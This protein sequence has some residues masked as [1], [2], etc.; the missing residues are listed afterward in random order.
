LLAGW[1]QRLGSAGVVALGV[2]FAC[3][4]FYW[5]TVRPLE[6]ALDSQRRAAALRQ[7][8]ES[9]SAASTDPRALELSR[10][11]GL[12]PSFADLPREIDRIYHLARDA[13]V[14]V[15]RGEYRLENA[16]GPLVEY[17]VAL[18]LRGRYVQVRN[19]L[20]TTLAVMPAAA[21]DSLQV[22]RS[23]ASETRIEAQLRMTLYF[24]PDAAGAE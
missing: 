11:Y 13:D 22:T 24:R 21:V 16:A 9:I 17:R 12:F 14:E 15:A 7:S 3:A 2:L 18:P 23:R 19:F 5:S 1:A 8:T 20:S 6:R 10:F 4:V